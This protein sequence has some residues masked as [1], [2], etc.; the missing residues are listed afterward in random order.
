M[1]TAE[2]DLFVSCFVLCFGG[3]SLRAEKLGDI[4]DFKMVC[5]RGDQIPIT[6]KV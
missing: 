4:H 6:F 5:G 1:L 3:N 2:Y